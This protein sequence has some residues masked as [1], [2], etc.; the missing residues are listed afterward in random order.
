VAAGPTVVAECGRNGGWRRR[1]PPGWWRRP[2]GQGRWRGQ[3]TGSGEVVVDGF[4]AAAAGAGRDGSV[5]G[6]ALGLVRKGGEG[7]RGGRR[8]GLEAG[9]GGGGGARGEAG[10][11]GEE[12]DR[13]RLS[14]EQDDCGLVGTTHDLL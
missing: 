12:D 3:E 7:D 10:P 14:R 1:R 2:V 6:E 8:A 13:V 9:G 5:A 4:G 11:S